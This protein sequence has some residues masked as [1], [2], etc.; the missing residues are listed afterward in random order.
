MQ[1]DK[2]PIFPNLNGLRTFGAIAVLL[3]H[4]HFLNRNL[5]G[6]FYESWFFRKAEIIISRGHLAI[7]LFFI[8]SGFLI[9][10]LMLHEQKRKGRISIGNFLARRFLRVWPLYFLVVLFGFFLFPHLPFG[11]PTVHEFWKFALFLS[12]YS[13]ITDGWRDGINF[14]SATWTVSVEEQF[15]LVWALLFGCFSLKN[16][17]LLAVF[18]TALIAGS[19]AFRYLNLDNQRMM[20]LHVLSVMSDL[21][22]GG[23]AALLAFSGFAAAFFGKLSRSVIVS[24]Y[25]AGI[26]LILFEDHIFQG[27]L[28]VYERLIPGLFLTFIVLEQVFASHSFF[29]TD[30]IPG[31][32]HIGKHT[33]AIYLFHCIVIW[34]AGHLFSYFGLPGNLL[35]YVVYTAVVILITWL[36]ARISYLWFEAPFLRMQRFFRD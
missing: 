14:L 11:L 3:Y 32:Y 13:E 35:F 30:R 9:T 34:Y 18:F 36:L 4:T 19:I 22:L 31:F 17:R 20:D 26:T 7:E 16:V 21:A 1:E 29:K 27:Q 24:C 12:N 2:H 6:D 25:L 15:Y 23:I 8:I 5:W 28:M 33:Y 10:S